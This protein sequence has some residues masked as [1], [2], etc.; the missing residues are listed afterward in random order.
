MKTVLPIFIFILVITLIPHGLSAE[1]LPS[2]SE[3]KVLPEFHAGDKL[4]RDAIRQANLIVLPAPSQ[5]WPAYGWSHDG[6]EYQVAVDHDGLIKFI[7]THSSQ[8]KMPSGAY[9]GMTLLD[10]RAA[11]DVNLERIQGWGWSA[12]L[13]SGWSAVFYCG[14][15]MTACEPR[16]S[17]RIG[18]IYNHY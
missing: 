9:V 8:L 13:P 7:S 15:T 18:M 3:Q 16:T 17:S 1:E 11:V 10:F 12:E 2:K 5:M 14:E 6:V 4:P